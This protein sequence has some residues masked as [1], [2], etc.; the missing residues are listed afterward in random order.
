[1]HISKEF[2]MEAVGLSLLVALIFISMQM[3]QKAM[4]VTNILGLEQ[5]EKIKMLEE[6]EITKY[7]ELLID[8][9]TAVSYIKNVVGEYGIPVIVELKQETFSVT[10]REEFSLLRNVNSK[11][12]ISPYTTF[13]CQVVRNENDIIIEIRLTNEQGGI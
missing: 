13:R 3:Y 5:E 11:M 4:R 7:D 9:M 12:Y 6:Y 1:M 8:G 2:L 10:A